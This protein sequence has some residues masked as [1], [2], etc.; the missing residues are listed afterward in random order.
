MDT[1]GLA[2]EYEE[3]LFYLPP[4]LREVLERVPEG[5]PQPV[6]HRAGQACR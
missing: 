5:Q 6:C 3:A 2:A 4:I 1:R